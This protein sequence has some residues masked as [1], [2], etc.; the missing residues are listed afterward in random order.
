M[1]P[2]ELASSSFTPP[3][4]EMDKDPDP[5]GRAWGAA[6]AGGSAAAST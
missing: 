3:R 4:K 6:V 2:A 1:T 5:P